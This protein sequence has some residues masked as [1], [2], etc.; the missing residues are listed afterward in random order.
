VVELAAPLADGDVQVDD[1]R[2]SVPVKD[3]TK[4]LVVMANSLHEA[5]IEPEDITLRRPTLDEVFL[6][7]TGA[8]A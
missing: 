3:R 8:A 4:A 6:H 2:V 7:L 5:K 1:V